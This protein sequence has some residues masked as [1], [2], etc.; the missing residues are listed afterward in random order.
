MLL[1]AVDT[2]DQ[3]RFTG[4]RRAADDDA[5]LSV[6]RQVDILQHMEVTIPFVHVF[7]F[8]DVI[9]ILDLSVNGD[10]SI[11]RIKKF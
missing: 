10:H 7:N 11:S 9:I 5:F 4:P 6:D 1:Q 2:A 8:D 3:G